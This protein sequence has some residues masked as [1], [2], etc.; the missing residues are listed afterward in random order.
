[1]AIAVYMAVCAVIS[2]VCVALMREQAGSLD[3]R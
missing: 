3:G 2:L 1:M